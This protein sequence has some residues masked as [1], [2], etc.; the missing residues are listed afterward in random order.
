MKKK[1]KYHGGGWVFDTNEGRY[2]APDR[3][4]TIEVESD[5]IRPFSD[6]FEFAL[7]SLEEAGLI[8]E[9]HEVYRIMRVEEG[10]FMRCLVDG[11]WSFWVCADS[12]DEALELLIEEFGV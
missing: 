7:M 4:V 10:Y 6:G 3:A 11:E 12:Y 1:Q 2:A 9:E 8:S 5:D